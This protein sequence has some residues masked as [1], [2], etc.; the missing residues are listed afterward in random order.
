MEKDIKLEQLEQS[1]NKLENKRNKSKALLALG[2]I[3]VAGTS[4]FAKYDGQWGDDNDSFGQLLGQFEGWIGGNLGKLLA[5]LGFIG[6]FVIYLMT[7]KGSVLFVG[8]VISLI[9]G[10]LTGIASVFFAAGNTAFEIKASDG[11]QLSADSKAKAAAAAKD[12]CEK[13]TN[14]DSTGKKYDEKTGECK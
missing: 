9:A 3:A 6:T 14:G 4:A 1:S 13:K 5:L 8:I 11:P 7:H 2:A 10:G 12:K